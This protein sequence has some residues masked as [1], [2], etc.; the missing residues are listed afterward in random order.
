MDYH[1]VYFVSWASSLSHM[2]IGCKTIM[3]D[4]YLLFHK[5][6]PPVCEVKRW[7]LLRRVHLS[8]LVLVLLLQ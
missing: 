4:I 5:V 3:H 6:F 2:E 8:D 1:G 7:L